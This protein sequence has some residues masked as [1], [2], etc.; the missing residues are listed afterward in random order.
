MI[1]TVGASCGFV[2]GV[3]TPAGSCGVGSAGS[4]CVSATLADAC[5]VGA[6]AD[7]SF[8]AAAATVGNR[9]AA[10]DRV[11]VAGKSRVGVAV[12]ACGTPCSVLQL[13]SELTRISARARISIRTGFKPVHPPL[14]RCA[15]TLAPYVLYTIPSS[16]PACRRN[17]R[18]V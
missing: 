13:A 6:G 1:V 15:G 11:G 10:A 17:V 14:R 9:V 8:V 5:P 2:V 18:R 3:G 12:P 7:P 16:G 4:G